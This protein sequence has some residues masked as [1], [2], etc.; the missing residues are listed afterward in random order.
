MGSQQSWGKVMPS[1]KNV[2]LLQEAKDK[3]GRSNAIFFADYQTITHKDLEGLRNTL[4][5]AGAEI[6]VSK[7]NLVNIAL[8]EKN[9]DAKEQLQ[10]PLAAVFSYDDPVKTAKA[11]YDF[12]KPIDPAKI[13]FGVF[14]G[15]LIDA[16]MVGALAATPPR[17]VLLGKL[18]GLLNSPLTNLVYNLNFN[19]AKLVYAL[20][21]IEKTKSS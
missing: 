20:K 17:E 3:V 10:G 11:I 19:T 1:Q 5:E 6:A 7:N 18:V 12:F 21:A 14:E 13:K 9:V 4:R 2:Q 15:N 8:Q 16:K